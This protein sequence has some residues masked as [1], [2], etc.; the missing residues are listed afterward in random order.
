MI[1]WENGR[2]HSIKIKGSIRFTSLFPK[3]AKL[4]S[5]DSFY[6]LDLIA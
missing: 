4:E 6:S 1:R 5:E 3:D 2:E